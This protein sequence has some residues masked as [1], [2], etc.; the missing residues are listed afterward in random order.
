MKN[1]LKF[2][3][4]G[5]ISL[6]VAFDAIQS[7]LRV[8]VADTGVG[9][10]PEE[11][12]TLFE[13][14]GRVHRT[15]DENHE[16]LGMGLVICKAIV[17]AN[18]GSIEAISQG[19]NMGSV[20][21]FSLAVTLPE[22]E[23]DQENALPAVVGD[24][25]RKSGAGKDK[26]KKKDKN[27]KKNDKKEKKARKRLIKDDKGLVGDKD[28]EA[29]A[30]AKDEVTLDG[31]DIETSQRELMQPPETNSLPALSKLI[32][33]RLIETQDKRADHQM[34]EDNESFP[35]VANRPEFS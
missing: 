24:L 16:G 35:Q 31:D 18:E 32:K 28:L 29:G 14:F 21:K 12:E 33:L 34:Q 5:Q 20:F 7:K 10:K 26:K 25:G 23:I 15:A 2:T 27:K 8:A 22:P 4:K 13:M 11:H 3:K 17:E 19:Q 6:F 1:A 9:I 30:D